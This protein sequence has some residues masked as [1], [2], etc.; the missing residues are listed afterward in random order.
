MHGR[1]AK[2]LED[3]APRSSE[4]G[5]QA[6]EESQP[7]SFLHEWLLLVVRARTAGNCGGSREAA[8]ISLDGPQRDR[9]GRVG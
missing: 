1:D 5:V 3:Q 8:A 4:S 7:C 9:V 6:N 2:G